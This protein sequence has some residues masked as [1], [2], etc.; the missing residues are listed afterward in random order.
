MGSLKFF[1]LKKIFL[2]LSRIAIHF[3][4]T[5]I[6]VYITNLSC[7][8]FYQI[9]ITIDKAWLFNSTVNIS[10]I[11]FDYIVVLCWKTSQCN[12]PCKVTWKLWRKIIIFCKSHGDVLVSKHCFAACACFSANQISRFFC[13][14]QN[15]NV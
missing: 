2:F 7:Q 1:F 9:S 13:Q 14:R 3:I 11:N 6:S 15:T 4:I 8:W 5:H 10:W 12:I